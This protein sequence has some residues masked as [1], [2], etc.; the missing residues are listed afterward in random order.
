[1]DS[2]DSDGR[3]LL[4]ARRNSPAVARPREL[5]LRQRQVLF[6]VG[7]GLS[8]H[9]IA[10]ALGISESSVATHLSRALRTLNLPSRAEWI[11]LAAEVMYAIGADG[12]EESQPQSPQLGASD[13]EGDQ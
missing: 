13:T 7:S 10:Y 8:N 11:R 6:Q 3:R 12:Q 2:F 4:L 5:P 9:E 1:V